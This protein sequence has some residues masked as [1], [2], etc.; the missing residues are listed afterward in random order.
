[1]IVSRTDARDRILAPLKVVADTQSLYTIYDD[2]SQTVPI[3]GTV[4]WARIS[5]RHRVGERTSLGRAD[6]KSKN[7][8]SGFIFVEIYTPREDGLID[9]DIIS[10]TFAE[11][12]RGG[13]DGDIWIGNVSEMEMGEDGN[14]FRTDIIAEFSYDLI[15]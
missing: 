13:Q 7:T 4:T 5:V 9:N 10:A 11:N 1:M 2:T 3:D 15:Q 14:W 12:L 6:G 8:M